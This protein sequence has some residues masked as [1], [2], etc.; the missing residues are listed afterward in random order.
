MEEI[1]ERVK[2][3]ESETT[4]SDVFK[5]IVINDKDLMES[6][7]KNSTEKA[8]NNKLAIS[9]LVL[10]RLWWFI[11][12][13]INKVEN[14][15]TFY[16][17]IEDLLYTKTY[18]KKLLTTIVK[19]GNQEK[20]IIKPK[21]LIA[22]NDNYRLNKM[23]EE[24]EQTIHTLKYQA[25]EINRIPHDKLKICSKCSMEL[26]KR[27]LLLTSVNEIFEYIVDIIN[28]VEDRFTIVLPKERTTIEN[29]K[30]LRKL[31]KRTQSIGRSAELLFTYFM[32]NVLR[33]HGQIRVDYQNIQT[34][35]NL[36]YDNLIVSRG[37]I[38]ISAVQIS[39]AIRNIMKYLENIKADLNTLRIITILLIIPMED[40]PAQLQNS[41]SKLLERGYQ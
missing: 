38:Q 4:I 20:S 37:I 41:L 7:I 33:E 19:I 29:A 15:S 2:N 6:I 13:L 1:E 30:T 36:I 21:V 26:Q 17:S 9:S 16:E 32:K 11:G 28:R 23:K 35:T 24:L 40:T 39:D 25:F 14:L 10:V 8:K 27:N 5:D 22:G 12:E 3:L 31:L 34:Q 18:P